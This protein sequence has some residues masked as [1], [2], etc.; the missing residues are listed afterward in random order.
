MRSVGPSRS[1]DKPGSFEADGSRPPSPFGRVELALGVQTHRQVAKNPGGIR[2]LLAHRRVESYYRLLIKHLSLGM[3]GDRKRGRTLFFKG[4]ATGCSTCH[5]VNGDG[6]ETGPDLS[7]IGGK[8]DRTHLIEAVLEPS[9]QIPA[10]FRVTIVVTSDGRV[11]TGIGKEETADTIT[12]EEA[13]GHRRKIAKA[14]VEARQLGMVSLM[15]EGLAAG[16]TPA[17]F[18]DLIA[19]LESLRTGRKPAPGDWGAKAT[20]LAVC[21]THS[22]HSNTCR[23]SIAPANVLTTGD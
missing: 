21:E 2:M 22:R 3:R 20:G 11:F 5:K 16:L 7:Q 8:F 13:G 15:P 1:D 6:S 10:E 18:T 12:L 4:T 14:E 9:A 19:F 23:I 17:E